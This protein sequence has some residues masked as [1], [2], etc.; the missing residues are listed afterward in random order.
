MVPS[1]NTIDLTGRPPVR[2]STSGE[3]SIDAQRLRSTGRQQGIG[4][5]DPRN[6][7]DL[8]ILRQHRPSYPPASWHPHLLKTP[9]YQSPPGSP[10]RLSLAPGRPGEAA[11]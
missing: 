3:L 11:E 4:A 9:Y 10:Q 2:R 1:S 7:D 5:A 6:P 8:L